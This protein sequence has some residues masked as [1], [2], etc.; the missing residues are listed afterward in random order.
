MTQRG[1][2]GHTI[3]E[4]LSVITI[5]TILFA[6][7]LLVSMEAFHG[8][9]RRSERDTFVSVLLRARSKAMANVQQHPWGVCYDASTPSDPKYVIFSGANYAGSF[10]KDIVPANPGVTMDLS[11]APGLL[12]SAGG[13]VFAQ[14]TGNTSAITVSMSQGAVQSTIRTN[15]VGQIDW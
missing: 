3:I 2:R 11:L 10:S 13:I 7:G 5:L 9:S 6:A 4:L 8:Y 12:C 15:A 1:E 14:L